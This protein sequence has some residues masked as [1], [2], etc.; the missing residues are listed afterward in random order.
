[1]A[2][3]PSEDRNNSREPVLPLAILAPGNL[4]ILSTSKISWDGI[5]V[6]SLLYRIDF[7]LTLAAH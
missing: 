5:G 6:C 1:V 2:S 4:W 7:L 3:K